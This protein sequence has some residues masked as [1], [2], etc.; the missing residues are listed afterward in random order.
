MDK[1]DFKFKQILPNQAWAGWPNG[2][3]S[4]SGVFCPEQDSVHGEDYGFES[5]VG[6]NFLLSFCY[7]CQ[8]EQV[9][10]LLI[11][12]LF[13]FFHNFPVGRIM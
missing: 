5:H 9:G 1:K 8:S 4:L 11:L 10:N 6:R 12:T 13:S 2:K 3:A 7:I